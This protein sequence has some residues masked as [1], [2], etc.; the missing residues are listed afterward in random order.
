MFT[1]KMWKTAN[2]AFGIIF[3]VLICIGFSGNIAKAKDTPPIPDLCGDN[4]DFTTKFRLQDCRYFKTIGK[5]P[6]FKLIPGFRWILE[7]IEEDDGGEEIRVREEVTVLCDTKWINLKGRW[8]K[9]RVVEERALEW[10]EEQEAYKAI[11]ISLN[12]FA[13]CNKTNDVYY[14]GEWSRD[15]EDGFDENDECEGEES[16]EG[17][18]EAG[19]HGAR[20]GIIMPGTFLLG[21]KYFQEVA[22][23]DAVDRA[24]HVDMGLPADVPAGM[25]SDCVMVID[26]NPAEGECGDDDAKIYC[27]E[28]GI[29]QDS[30]LELVYYGYVGCDDDNHDN[31]KRRKRKIYHRRF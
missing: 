27:P 24:E 28:V 18:W 10:D 2:S 12:W 13:I 6:Y 22:P 9:T 20:P 3:V 5:N 31:H 17:S 8:I 19:K 23:P 30:I 21:S 15:C 26:T 7:G 14:F 25:W 1:K 29:V 16:N 4:D 11:E